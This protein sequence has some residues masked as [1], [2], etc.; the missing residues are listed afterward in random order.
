MIKSKTGSAKTKVVY[1]ESQNKESSLEHSTPVYNSNKHTASRLWLMSAPSIL[2]CLLALT[3]S[4]ARSLPARSMNVNLN[5]HR[6]MHTS[7]ADRC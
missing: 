6:Y 4:E 5:T 1:T 2:A 3:A 7:L